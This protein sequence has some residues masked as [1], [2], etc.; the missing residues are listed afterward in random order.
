[1]I[2]DVDNRLRFRDVSVLRLENDFVLIDDGLE[3]GE[4]V[5]LSPI[6]T[7]VDGMRVSLT[8]EPTADR[9]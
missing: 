1:L 7:V 5:N 8:L 4:V 3:S 9:G 6:Q 2:I